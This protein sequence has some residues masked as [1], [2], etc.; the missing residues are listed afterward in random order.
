[1]VIEIIWGCALQ[2]AKHARGPP[3]KIEN[4]AQACCQAAARWFG[5]KGAMATALSQRSPSST[6]RACNLARNSR[7]SLATRTHNKPQSVSRRAI[8]T[9]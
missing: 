6:C 1:M 9:V 8:L 4:P 5:R 3:T 7:A 2:L